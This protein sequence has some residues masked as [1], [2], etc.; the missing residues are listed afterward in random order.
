M[1]FLERATLSGRLIYAVLLGAFFVMPLG[2]GPFTVAEGAILAVWLFSGA[3]WIHRRDYL[4]AAWFL[5]VLFVILLKGV[6]LIY[7]PDLEGMGLSYAKKAHYWLIPFAL[8]GLRPSR[9]AGHLLLYA[10]FAGLFVNACTGFL[11]ALKVVPVFADIGNYA[12]IGFY[13]G[14][15]TLAALLILGMLSA[16]Y[17]FRESERSPRRVL[18]GFLMAA[19]FLH[20]VIIESRGGHMAFA[21]LSPLIIYNVLP[22]RSMKWTVL[23]YCLLIAAMLASPIARHRVERTV[24]Q[25]HEHFTAEESVVW[26]KSY[27]KG[28]DRIYMWRWA[29]DL[30]LENPLLGVGTGGYQKAMLAGGAE[31]GV[32]HPHNNFLHMAVSYGVL[33]IAAF[34]WLFL[35]LLKTGWR[36]RQNAVGFFTLSSTLVLLIG[37]MTETHMLDAGG[38]FLLAVTAGLQTSLSGEAASNSNGFLTP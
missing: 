35:T 11:Q 7:T 32:A 8:S 16:S 9:R 26:G 15:N 13:G 5:P 19:Y 24:E 23:I 29:V 20:L 25:I 12:Y 33:G 18:F 22:R 10:F 36:H 28:L 34:I 31:V 21:V 38:A 37:G 4:A 3:F 27:T 30:F 14:H 1:P 17:F 2:T 6:G